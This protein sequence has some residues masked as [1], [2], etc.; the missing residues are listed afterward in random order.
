MDRRHATISRLNG[1]HL[2]WLASVT[3][4]ALLVGCG[5]KQPVTQMQVTNDAATNADADVML[6]GGAHDAHVVADATTADANTAMDATFDASDD[7]GALIDAG[8]ADDA[9]D[10]SFVADADSTS[11]AATDAA[12]DA[13]ACA[14]DQHTCNG[15]C[16]PLTESCGIALPTACDGTPGSCGTAGTCVRDY[17]VCSIGYTM[18]REGCCPVT[19]DTQ[20]LTGVVGDHVQLE[21][22]SDGTAYIL[23][24]SE[25]HSSLRLYAHAPGGTIEST[26][27]AIAAGYAND[28]F[29]FAV[30]R[31]GTVVIASMG[32]D[33]G[34]GCD[35]H[36]TT[37]VPGAGDT[38]T[39]T[40]GGGFGYDIG[41][42]LALDA[43]DTAWI[44]W[45]TARSGGMSVYSSTTAGLNRSYSAYS[46][47]TIEETDVEC[48]GTGSVYSA[49]A[50]AYTGTL[51]DSVNL[52]P[53]TMSTLPCRGE[54][55]AFDS[56]STSWSLFTTYPDF[57]TTLCR[58]GTW[59]GA[60]S[61]RAPFAIP[62]DLPGATLA[63][64]SEDAGYV[65]WYDASSY[66][67]HW[68]A[69]TD[70]RRWAGGTFSL[71][72]GLPA[73]WSSSSIPTASV[74]NATQPSGK[75]GF[76]VLPKYPGMGSLTL[77]EFQ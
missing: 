26:G 43:D 19:Q 1:A 71:D 72:F 73:G 56:M 40:I 65:V 66:T 27:V 36:L 16:V 25:D 17:C 31:D 11:D 52:L 60:L 46:N 33:F 22:A 14:S 48:D 23:V 69:S 67:A 3:T 58:D 57:D 24:E 13:G 61:A 7:A 29:D 6:D 8:S 53:M 51:I 37:W 74:S 62:S 28:S 64:D 4:A 77:V 55:I 20:T 76:V 44:T 38:T 30:R 50:H 42:G 15:T 35:V 49:W 34:E 54:D 41:I 75:M 12:I 21:Y 45:S 70:V 2:F 47:G 39:T 32:P 63:I 18:C 9:G 59:Q 10:A 5:G 68:I